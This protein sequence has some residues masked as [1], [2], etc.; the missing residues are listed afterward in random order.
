MPVHK[1]LHAVNNGM[2]PSESM[3]LAGIEVKPPDQTQ[4]YIAKELESIVP[5][6]E[7][8]WTWKIMGDSSVSGPAIRRPP[9]YP[10]TVVVSEVCAV[11]DVGKT[12]ANPSNV[13]IRRSARRGFFAFNLNFALGLGSD[14]FTSFSFSLR[15]LDAEKFFSIP[16]TAFVFASAVWNTFISLR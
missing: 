8:H 4:T 16:L 7:N 12:S 6:V 14:I 9:L 10:F 11:V 2:H 3:R 1:Q 5:S 15:I 13:W